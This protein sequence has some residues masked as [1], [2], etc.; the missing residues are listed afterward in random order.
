MIGGGFDGNY[1][2]NE[3]NENIISS[4]GNGTPVPV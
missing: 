4:L 1:Y 3:G 2:Y